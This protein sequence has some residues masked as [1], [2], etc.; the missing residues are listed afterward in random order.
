VPDGSPSGDCTAGLQKIVH[1]WINPATRS[2]VVATYGEIEEWDTSGVT[3]IAYLLT[4][5]QTANADLSKW[6]TS[7]VTT[8]LQGMCIYLFL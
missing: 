8:M 1:D 4:N 3:S 6:D 5:K 7:K 2:G